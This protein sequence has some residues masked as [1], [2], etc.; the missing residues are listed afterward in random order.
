ML[1]FSVRIWSEEHSLLPP[2]CSP[3]A[4]L[5][6]LKNPPPQDSE[7]LPLDHSDQL[8]STDYKTKNIQDMVVNIVNLLEMIFQYDHTFSNAYQDNSPLY[9]L[10]F[11]FHNLHTF[12]RL[13]PKLISHECRSLFRLRMLHYMYLSSNSPRNSQWLYH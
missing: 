11:W 9:I 7:H 1:Q 8:Q 4:F 3:P 12:P 5:V 6:L 10:L 13:T 2:S